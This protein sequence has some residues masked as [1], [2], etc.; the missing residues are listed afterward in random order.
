MVEKVAIQHAESADVL[1]FGLMTRG[2]P[3]IVESPSSS[4]WVQLK[5]EQVSFVADPCVTWLR[6][7]I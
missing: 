5:N 4:V 3:G 1:S 6:V 7:I 2:Q